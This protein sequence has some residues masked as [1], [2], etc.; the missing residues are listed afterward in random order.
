MTTETSNA[1]GEWPARYACN[2]PEGTF[3]TDDATLAN[4]LIAAAF[5]RDEWTV[6][7]T[8]NPTAAAPPPGAPQPPSSPEPEVHSYD[9]TDQRESVTIRWP[10]GKCLGYVLDRTRYTDNLPPSAPVGVEW[11]YHP[12]THILID[13][14]KRLEGGAAVLAEWDRARA[15]VDAALAQPQGD[16]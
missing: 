14:L 11:R 12:C 15:L 3:W 8:Q 13:G 4:K 6:T 5:D 16:K 10:D 2:G 7:D 9:P 1:R